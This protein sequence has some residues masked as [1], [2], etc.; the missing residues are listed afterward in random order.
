LKKLLC[1]AQLNVKKNCVIEM[2]IVRNNFNKK[3]IEWNARSGV[4]G[5][6]NRII[7]SGFK[8]LHVNHSDDITRLKKIFPNKSSIHNYNFTF[9]GKIGKEQNTE[10]KSICT[11]KF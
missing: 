8:R 1:C 5:F 9:K 6:T 3:W 7:L 11:L 4:G 10:D 2:K